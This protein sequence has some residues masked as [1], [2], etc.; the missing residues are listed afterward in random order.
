MS[1]RHISRSRAF[2]LIELL[3]VI[4]IIALLIG[5]LIPALGKARTTARQLKCL[6]QVRDMGTAML[7]YA[8]DNK[9]A[10]PV[11]PPGADPTFLGS[12][13][14][15]TGGLAG[16]FSLNQAGTSLNPAPPANSSEDRRG[17]TGIDID[18]DE[19]ALDQYPAWPANPGG[20]RRVP[21]MRSYLSTLNILVCPSD[22]EDV[23]YG[24]NYST[25]W[26]YPTNAGDLAT[27]RRV[28]I[29]P[30]S[31]RE[32][33][34]PNISYLYIAGLK[35]D[36]PGIPYP[37]PLFGD[38]TNG[39]DR[40]T[41][42]WYGATVDA[43]GIT[44]NNAQM[45]AAGVQNPG[46]YGRVDNHGPQG[47]NFVYADGHGAFTTGNIQ[48]IFFSSPTILNSKSI[49]STNPNRSAFVETID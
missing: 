33:S 49:N 40:K 18:N 14:G 21:L 23:W 20:N 22:R 1:H 36:E 29:V 35:T 41:Q 12:Q 45:D 6:A 30:G 9:S 5:I 7:F 2:T 47:A 43:N 4:A 31:E 3:V 34:A 24:Q 44:A 16:L 15:S 37:P 28:P 11:K 8:N 38:E 17:W 48:A 25:A 39:P 13:S 10:F 32:V 46:G 27:R 19:D 42:A 26:A